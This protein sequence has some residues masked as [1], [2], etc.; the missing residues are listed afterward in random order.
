MIS[1]AFCIKGSEM[2]IDVF[3]CWWQDWAMPRKLRVEYEDAQGA[4][5]H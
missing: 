3:L 2:T 1:N 5:E 4:G